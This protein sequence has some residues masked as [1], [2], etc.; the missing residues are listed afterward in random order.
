MKTKV[1]YTREIESMKVGKQFRDAEDDDLLE[2]IDGEWSHPKE[3]HGKR[4][5]IVRESK[6]ESTIGKVYPSWMVAYGT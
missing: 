4:S 5:V 1:Y 6:Y 2:V 3:G